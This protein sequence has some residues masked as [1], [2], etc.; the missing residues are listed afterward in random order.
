MGGRAVSRGIDTPVRM[1]LHLS[2]PKRDVTE[3]EV[4]AAL[5]DTPTVSAAAELLGVSRP[6]LYRLMARFGIEVRRI[7]A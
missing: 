7:V 3:R 6:T 1:W 4:R 2:M 5:R